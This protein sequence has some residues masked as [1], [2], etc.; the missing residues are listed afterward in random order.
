[1]TSGY[2]G[3]LSAG[4]PVFQRPDGDAGTSYYYEAIQVT[5][6]TSGTYVFTSDST[7]DTMG[8]LYNSSFDPS[9]P[10]KNLIMEDDDSG[11][12]PLQFRMR[13]YLQSG[14][15]YVLVVT[16]HWDVSTGS[17]SV[18]AFGPSPLSLVS[19]TPSTSQPIVTCKFIGISIFHCCTH[20]LLS[21][22]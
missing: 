4:S 9:K 16:T 12:I 20:C 13:V 3:A 1:M 17:F 21:F 5:I 7:I 18:S 11:D 19:I 14:R 22:F 8:Y 15:T 6:P 10:L 2:S